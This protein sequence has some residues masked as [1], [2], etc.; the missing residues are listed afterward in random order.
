MEETDV[1]RPHLKRREVHQLQALMSNR[2]GRPVSATEAVM[3]VVQEKIHTLTDEG[4]R[5]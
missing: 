3:A 2:A 1:I 5:R 4:E